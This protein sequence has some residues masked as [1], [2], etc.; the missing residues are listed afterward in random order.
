MAALRR[1]L[2]DKFEATRHWQ[3]PNDV[4]VNAALAHG[5]RRFEVTTYEE[6]MAAQASSSKN[7]RWSSTSEAGKS[8]AP[9]PSR[10]DWRRYE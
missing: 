1:L 7:W 2:R 8:K 10:L 9:T 4:P 6:A 5:L 3:P